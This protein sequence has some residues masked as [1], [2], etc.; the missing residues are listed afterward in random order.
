MSKCVEAMNTNV[1]D[2]INFSQH[3]KYSTF[4][5]LETIV[6][7]RKMSR[8]QNIVARILKI[9]QAPL[10]KMM[11]EIGQKREVVSENVWDLLNVSGPKFGYFPKPLKTILIEIPED[12]LTAEGI[13]YGTGVNKVN[14]C[15][16]PV[17]RDW[18]RG[19]KMI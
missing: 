1:K 5:K 2:V 9:D 19:L 3:V 7:S 16:P 12:L 4:L 10:C 14:F 17:E 6:L 11:E 8:I 15:G 13:F 18:K